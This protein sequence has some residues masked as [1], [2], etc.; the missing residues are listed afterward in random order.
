MRH[1][2]RSGAIVV[3]AGAFLAMRAF[4]AP[5]GG[6][7]RDA[8]ELVKVRASFDADPGWE[9]VNNRVVATGCPT[10]RQ[11]FGWSPTAQTGARGEIGG[12][13]WRSRRPAYY[14]MR[15]DPPLTMEMPLSAS[16]KIVVKAV[17]RTTGGAYFGFFNSRRQEWRPWSSMAVRVA[18]AR[19]DGP[20][21]PL[22]IYDYM[23]SGW[24][25]GGYDTVPIPADGS[26]H[27]W[28]MGWEPDAVV[29]GEWPD[30]RLRGYLDP[31]RRM[32]GEE[33]LQRGRQ[34][35]P[36][37]T[38]AALRQR[39]EAARDAGLITFQ[40]RRG[41]GWEIRKEPEKVRGRMWFRLDGGPTV[42][43][44]IDVTHR[45]ESAV[46]DRFGIFNMQLPGLPMELYL[47]DLT[48]NGKK[49]DLSRDPGWESKGSR[50]RFVERDFHARQDFGYSRTRFA[51]GRRGE[52]GGTF[53]R[54][55]PV[56]PLHGYYA[57]DVGTL[58]LDDP[59][60]FSGNIAFTAGATDAGMFFGYFNRKEKMVA[61]TGKDESGAPLPQTMG[62]AIDGPTRIGYFFSTEF[63][64]TRQL[65]SHG[66]GPIF[67]P[68][69]RPHVFTFQYD[70]KANSG[71][72]QIRFTM[73]D[74]TFRHDITTEQRAARATFDRFGLMNIRRGGK[75]VTVY[76]DDLSYTARRRPGM[77]PE[78]H[79]QEVV[80][81]AY[82]E[83][84]RRY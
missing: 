33:I 17:N 42:S 51:G 59:I 14:A 67:V 34:V 43:N 11:D 31:Q 65:V 4:S 48:V 20:L 57:D 36:D 1:H 24:K 62:F 7:A 72:G 63:A 60:Q 46:Y 22:L 81:V 9:A 32:P 77:V 19:G 50:E 74:Q 61:L 58:T 76:L 5:P 84:G 66:Q 16:G 41:V 73:D 21:V 40:T 15:L 70:P 82:P 53:W 39:L 37:L 18:D 68:D 8:G 6:A 2:T 56:D 55:E 75:Y 35:E 83:G 13:V 44:F 54:T 64:P 12:T 29:P 79:R 3:A 26:V 69:G 80:T 71:S 10:V 78:R 38:T 30:A 45:Q 27:S 52:I 23:T 49:I 28:G 47:G 25:A